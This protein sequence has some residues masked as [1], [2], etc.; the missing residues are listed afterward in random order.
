MRDARRFEHP[1]ADE[2]GGSNGMEDRRESFDPFFGSGVRRGLDETRRCLDR[3]WLVARESGEP[4]FFGHDSCGDRGIVHRAHERVAIESR[5]L[6]FGHPLSDR[7]AGHRQRLGQLHVLP[8]RTNGKA[9]ASSLGK[10]RVE[11]GFRFARCGERVLAY[12]EEIRSGHRGALS[13]RLVLRTALAMDE[14]R[15]LTE[16]LRPRRSAVEA[17]QTITM[18]FPP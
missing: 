18:R 6:H 10:T 3:E 9:C 15:T 5:R 2:A 17:I 8:Q 12:G 7:H 14:R 1:G 11:L 16:S 13:S 4:G